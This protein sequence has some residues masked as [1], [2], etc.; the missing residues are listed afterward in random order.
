MKPLSN[1]SA[2]HFRDVFFGGNWATR[3][4]KDILSDVTW[5]EAT[6][7]IHDFNTIATLTYH[8]TYYIPV[9]IDVLE[10][11]PLSGKDELSFSHPTISSK[12]DW[13]SIQARGWKNVERAADLIDQLPEDQLNLPFTDERFG[14]YF[15][16]I[17]GIIEHT[18]Y[19]LGQIVILKRLIQNK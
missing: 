15:R 9:L 17:H 2:K 8:V 5:E 4:L 18:H 7:S 3:N 14:T 19:H 1:Q 16:N 13:E 10:G 11:K 12:E 6:T